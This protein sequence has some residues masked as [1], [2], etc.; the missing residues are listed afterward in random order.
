MWQPQQ[1]GFPHRHGAYLRP[2]VCAVVLVICCGCTHT[3]LQRNTISQGSTLTD[4]QYQQVLDNVAM[5]ACNPDSLAWHIKINSGLVQ[6]AD[7]GSGFLGANLGGPGHL[8]PNLG[9]QRNV[10]HQWNVDP[11]IEAEDLKL[12]QLAYRKAVNPSD[13]E[14]TIKREAYEQ[15]CELSAGFHIA[16]AR[17]VAFDMIHSL[18]QTASPAKQSKLDRIKIELEGLY[19][20]VDELSEKAQAYDATQHL[21]TGGAAPSKLE[22]LKEELIRLTSEVGDN[23]VEPVG[24][25]YRPGRNVGLIEQAQDRIEALIKL[26]E[27]PETGESNQFSVPWFGCGGKKEVPA[28]AC[29]VGCYRGCGRECY[30]WVLPER[31]KTFRDFILVILSLAPPDA[32]DSAST[33]P[34]LGAANSANF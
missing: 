19:T 13:A 2:A 16:L 31:M 20:Q 26:V 10:L 1:P 18:R 32:Q 17:E 34:G 24:A 33:S 15:I 3:R 25:Y 28:C 30:V 14:G 5:F 8:V 6:V 11:V 21:A 12:L 27:E 23:P 9:L 29:L 7:Q 22:F 4:L